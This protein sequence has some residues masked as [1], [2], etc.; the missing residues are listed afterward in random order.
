[1]RSPVALCAIV[2]I[3]AGCAGISS[4]PGPERLQALG[5]PAARRALER[6]GSGPSLVVLLRARGLAELRGSIQ[7][8]LQ[9]LDERGKAPW[10]RL[11]LDAIDSLAAAPGASPRVLPSLDRSRPL[12]AGLFEPWPDEVSRAAV[13]AL[14]GLPAGGVP[15][16]LHRVWLP[17]S[18][19][20]ELGS[21]L[22]ALLG[23]RGFEPVAWEG[24]EP[25]PEGWR[26]F[27]AERSQDWI[28]AEQQADGLRLLIATRD[29]L[30]P[31]S[32]EQ[33]RAVLRRLIQEPA[34]AWPARVRPAWLHLLGQAAPLLVHFDTDRLP[35]LFACL[36][37]GLLLAALDSVEP[38]LVEQLS[39]AGIAELS[40]GRLFLTAGRPELDALC[41]SVQARGQGLDLRLVAD[42]SA[43]GEALAGL[44]LGGA[45]P[46]LQLETPARAALDLQL[47]LARSAG[48]TRVPIEGRDDEHGYAMQLMRCGFCCEL[49]LLLRRPGALI[50]LIAKV[51][52]QKA[53]LPLPRS[54]QLVWLDAP[55]GARPGF[56]GALALAAAFA[57]GVEERAIR[58]LIAARG[59]DS[60]IDMHFDELD[61]RPWLRLGL[62]VDPRRVFALRAAERRGCAMRLRIDARGLD[63]LQLPGGLPR[64]G[65]AEIELQHVQ[66]AWL[67]RARLGPQAS[68]AGWDRDRYAGLP[69]PPEEERS[70]GM[71]CLR[72]ATA[73][74]ARGLQARAQAAPDSSALLVARAYTESLPAIQ[75][76]RASPDS[77]DMAAR[78]D[79][80]WTL[81]LARQQGRAFDRSTQL[82]ILDSA[83]KRRLQAAC[84]QADRVRSQPELR[85]LRIDRRA[86]KR[87][88]ASLTVRLPPDGPPRPEPG[89][90]ADAL[91]RARRRV[92]RTQRW[93]RG[94]KSQ[95]EVS[96]AVDA[97]TPVV[98]FDAL[99]RDLGAAGA[100]RVALLLRT[101]AGLRALD[102]ALSPV[103]RA[104][105]PKRSEDE[106]AEARPRRGLL[107]RPVPEPAFERLEIPDRFV[108]LKLPGAR[109][110]APREEPAVLRVSG[111]GWS[112][113][114]RS[115]KIALNAAEARELHGA[116]G[117][118]LRELL[119]AAEP[120]HIVAEEGCG[121]R[122]LVDALAMASAGREQ[123]PLL[124]PLPPAVAREVETPE[125]SLASVFGATSG[126]GGLGG[127][128][129]RVAGGGGG[130]GL[131]GLATAG[132]GR[133]GGGLARVGG[134]GTLRRDKPRVRLERPSVRGS[135][136]QAVVRRVLRRYRRMLSFCVERAKEPKLA[137]TIEASWVIA[138]SGRV[139]K[140]TKIEGSLKNERVRACV[141]R[142]ILRM[143]FPKP[144]GGGVVIVTQPMRFSRAE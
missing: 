52:G 72:Q 65:P 63:P 113:Q 70:R 76:A 120:L 105:E 73:A 51:H 17:A 32:P 45:A 2:F 134:L 50:G 23:Q 93:E 118:E 138:G 26:L 21:E 114:S 95:A 107:G 66:G 42:P 121:M 60:K 12:A 36:E 22:A 136:D 133:G 77:R 143:R 16:V 13:H 57:P 90:L 116:L 9:A 80:E 141:R 5:D 1:M 128:F 18:N 40:L 46:A 55:G 67:L 123:A 78:M 119:R 96:L 44:A 74:L 35:D 10:S 94:E 53:G 112:F 127:G 56:P 6:L 81:A 144:A 99:L 37:A 34:R 100:R 97:R 142:V 91:R 11:A 19:A 33:G 110:R 88:A 124:G 47:D 31:E 71:G 49:D 24:A 28:A 86:G 41:A 139:S 131:G 89:G 29:Q 87:P 135:L 82:A 130:L 7:A 85:L 38:D 4:L 132:S 125:G 111:Q 115:R 39:A 20:G 92:E 126:I 54:L 15:P 102:A 62:G 30:A 122:D 27:A 14:P 59:L 117:E 8:L 69:L 64:P 140:V 101:P 25:L 58:R 103:L 137:G 109:S 83:C 3:L 98:R 129:D 61:G 108:G 84:A 43:H 68:E 75:C 106:P 48:S 104:A 79:R